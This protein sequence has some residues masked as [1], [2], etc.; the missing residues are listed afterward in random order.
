MKCTASSWRFIKF[1]LSRSRFV[2]HQQPSS[3]WLHVLLWIGSFSEHL[4]Q[5]TPRGEGAVSPDSSSH[6]STDPQGPQTT[7]SLRPEK[8][9]AVPK[10][11]KSVST[12][13]LSLM[14]PG[15]ESKKHSTSL[16]EKRNALLLLILGSYGWVYNLKKDTSK[17]FG[18][19][20]VLTPTSAVINPP[21]GFCYKNLF[22]NYKIPSVFY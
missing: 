5:L 18:P 11:P 1:H 4:D 10:V 9:V 20:E 8:T 22:H 16:V 15:G 19:Y 21:W 13:A 12:G 6:A 7:T 3:A 2:G 17:S 14:I